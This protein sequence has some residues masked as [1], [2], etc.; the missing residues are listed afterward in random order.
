MSEHFLSVRN[1]T[2]V[3]RQSTYLIVV[4]LGQ[5][6]ALISGGID[7]SVGV[8][9]ALSS[10]ICALTM[11][12]LSTVFPESIVL[13]IT[14]G[15]LMRFLGASLMGLING[16]GIAF[17]GVSPFMMTLGLTSIGFGTALYLTAGIPVHGMP[18]EFGAIFGFGSFYGIP[19]P[20]YVTAAIVCGMSLLM[21]R[22]VL[23]RYFYAIGGNLN[24]ARL[25]GINPHFSLLA[26][27]VLCSA[28][29]ALS[30]LMLTAR[31]A[32][33]EANIGA[34]LPLESIAACVIGE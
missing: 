15:A 23:G 16:V 33:G 29:T 2:N 7:L 30:G 9:V 32:T 18:E 21:N 4:S 13:I 17:L 19:T 12:A 31:L 24:A 1:I 34:A 28:L 11:S 14:L 8:T 10:V 22:T 27:Y 3:A 5:M 6:I 25:S 20:I 26:A